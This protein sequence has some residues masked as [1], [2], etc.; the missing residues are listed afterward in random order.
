MKERTDLMDKSIKEKFEGHEV[1]VPSHL[2]NSIEA[3][4]PTENNNTG[5]NFFFKKPFI[6]SILVI[7]T[8]IIGTY[9][10][11]TPDTQNNHTKTVVNETSVH[12]I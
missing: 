10:Y 4:L 8:V 9:L 5:G 2:W 12:A 7:S 1:P 11:K 3:N 6:L